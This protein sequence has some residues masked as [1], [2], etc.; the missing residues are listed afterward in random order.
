MTPGERPL[1]ALLR[2]T[3]LAAPLA[4]PATREVVV[5]RPG[6]YGVER[7]G[8]WEWHD[9]PA[10]TFEHLD[11]IGI[12]AASMSGKDVD[13]A[14][15]LCGGTLPDGQRIQICR[16][17]ATKP[18]VISLTMRKPSAEVRTVDEDDFSALF[19]K[20]RAPSGRRTALD[21]QLMALKAAGDWPDLFRLAVRSRKTIAVTG[22]TGSG[23]TTLL[24]RLMHEVPDSERL[25]TI[26]DAD[27]FGDM[28]Q[29]N[30]V[31]LF[32]SSGSQSAAALSA[33]DCVKAALRMR[34]DR[35]MIQELRAGD[36][37]AFLRV[38]AAGHP[39]SVTTWHAEEGE[40]FDAL[41]LMVRQHPAGNTI[42]DAKIRQY[43]QKHLDVV[44]WC[45]RGD[46]GFS[47]P[48]VWLRA[49]EEAAPEIAA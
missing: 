2:D 46:D 10:L 35:V 34:P 47:A 14:H 33:E 26:E 3:G 37:F 49:E 4:D 24:R 20:A 40:A 13:D 31:A 7:R 27:E 36:A 38:L 8:E 15:P 45:D 9:A 23:K 17:S 5:N 29:R 21:A 44:V 1:R 22:K 42:P 25:V 16:P 39:G 43:L 12:L 30:R 32:H 48:Y 6:E 19:A 11:M 18:G 28:R 41:E